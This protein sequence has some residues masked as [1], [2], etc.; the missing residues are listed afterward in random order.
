MS[1]LIFYIHVGEELVFLYL[2]PGMLLFQN[3][4][5]SMPDVGIYRE[6]LIR[7]DDWMIPIGNYFLEL[8]FY[9]LFRF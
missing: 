4:P 3:Y 8:I 1:L 9:I 2:L 5:F 7:I 6:S